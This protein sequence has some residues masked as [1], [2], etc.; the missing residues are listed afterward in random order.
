MS[1]SSVIESPAIE[2]SATKAAP[3]AKAARTKPNVANLVKEAIKPKG[4]I[5]D[6]VR[7]GGKRGKK[8]SDSLSVTWGADPEC[9]IAD[10]QQDGKIVSSIHI[11]K[12][13]KHDPID[14]GNG[15]MLYADN[16]LGEFSLSPSD[17]KEEMLDRMKDAFTR[18]HEHLGDRYILVPKAAHLYPDDEMIPGFNIDPMAIGCNPSVDCLKESLNM[19]LPFSDN[20]R[21]GSF[22][23]HVGNKAWQGKHDGRLLTFNSRHDAIK[24]LTIYLGLGSVI[25]SRDET[26]RDRRKIYGRAYEAR[27]TGYGVEHRSTE[28]YPLRSREM[29]ALVLD[30]AEHAINHIKTRTEQ[31]IIKSVDLHAVGAAVNTCDKVAALAILSKLDLPSGLMARIQKDYGMPDLKAG[32]GL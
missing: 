5:E 20:T 25:F 21:T 13:D 29:T 18:I 28:P 23:I 17:T 19:P 32:W 4:R 22:H 12:R 31:D 15:V 6:L 27:V 8:V 1:T 10:L 14:L 16:L 2:S 3:R 30:L 24:L 11:L 26:S 7:G 9:H